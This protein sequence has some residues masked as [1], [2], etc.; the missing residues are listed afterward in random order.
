MKEEYIDGYIDLAEKNNVNIT[1]DQMTEMWDEGEAIYKKVYATYLYY[2]KLS[3]KD[4]ALKFDAFV[5][6]VQKE[7]VSYMLEDKLPSP[8]T[9]LVLDETLMKVDDIMEDENADQHR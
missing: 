3:G 8:W 2:E 6:L 5:E 9:A 4:E 7:F 1:R